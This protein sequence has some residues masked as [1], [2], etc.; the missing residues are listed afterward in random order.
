MIHNTLQYGIRILE[1]SQSLARY[2]V[3]YQQRFYSHEL[4]IFQVFDEAFATATADLYRIVEENSRGVVQ[5]IV[6][7]LVWPCGLF[8]G[9][10]SAARQHQIFMT[11]F[12][13]TTWKDESLPA[14]SQLV[15]L[16][17]S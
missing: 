8:V 11:G 4:K 2:P 7:A 3:V 14:H 13:S 5:R 15:H 10:W 6:F 9:V 12:C 16:W 1:V 17:L